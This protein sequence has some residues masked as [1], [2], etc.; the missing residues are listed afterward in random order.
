M[1]AYVLMRKAAPW[2]TLA[3]DAQDLAAV[4]GGAALTSNAAGA[5]DAGNSGRALVGAL[6]ALSPRRE[7]RKRATSPRWRATGRTTSAI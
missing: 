7:M 1:I 5:S 4:Q 2:W 3:T 6:G